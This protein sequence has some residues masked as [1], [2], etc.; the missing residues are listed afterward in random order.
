MGT[1]SGSTKASRWGIEKETP[2]EYASEMR[3]RHPSAWWTA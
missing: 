3:W 1:R 2:S